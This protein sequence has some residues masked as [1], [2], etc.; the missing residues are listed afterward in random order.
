MRAERRPDEHQGTQDKP[1]PEPRPG[2]GFFKEIRKCRYDSG[3]HGRLEQVPA[4]E[5]PP[6]L[7]GI[8][9]AL[10]LPLFRARRRIPCPLG[11]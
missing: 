10:I 9:P 6:E 7:V 1:N 11:V 5:T 3:Y 8:H 2:N 4:P